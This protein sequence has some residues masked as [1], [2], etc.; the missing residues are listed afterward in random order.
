M[1]ILGPRV[2]LA[3]RRGWTLIEI[4]LALTLLSVAV[5]AYARTIAMASVANTTSRE[6]N[7]AANAAKRTIAVLRTETF[8]QIFRR[9]NS[10]V[11][12]DP[13]GVVCPGANFAVTGLDAADGDA[14]GFPGEI[15]FPT[16][17]AA[18]VL[19]LREDVVDAKLG[20][21]SDLNGGGIDS[22]DHAADYQR[23]PV[24]VRVRWRGVGGA[25]QVEFTTV[26]GSY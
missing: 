14:D 12:D 17:T 1:E 26:L 3:E 5:V 25:G 20:M 22:N 23:L 15:V 7:L 18:G 11:A 21:P 8:D 9:Y 19:Q 10:S 6:A 4:V 2:R 16:S 13:G 24:L